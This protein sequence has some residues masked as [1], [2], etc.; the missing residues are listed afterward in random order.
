MTAAPSPRRERIIHVDEFCERDMLRLYFRFSREF[1]DHWLAPARGQEFAEG[2]S[3][4]PP[5]PHL[6]TGAKAV[7]F[8]V[9][10]VEDWWH[11]YFRIGGVPAGMGMGA[12]AGAG[13]AEPAPRRPQPVCLPASAAG[14]EP[15][16]AMGTPVHHRGSPGSGNRAPR[17]RPHSGEPSRPGT[18]RKRIGCLP[19]DAT[20]EQ[21]AAHER[22]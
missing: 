12:A 1:M 3:A 16:R 2:R 15:A 6:I 18:G 5:M 4:I 13:A 11:T 10:D 9:D 7:T 20:E 17:S 22:S 8:R 14:S 19:A 21:L